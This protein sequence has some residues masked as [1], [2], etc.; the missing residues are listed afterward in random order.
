M[1]QISRIYRTI[2]QSKPFP[3]ENELFRVWS[4]EVH[5]RDAINFSQVNQSKSDNLISLKPELSK[6]SL[7][8][9]DLVSSSWCVC[10]DV[11]QKYPLR[12][13]PSA[14]ISVPVM[15]CSV[16]NHC[17]VGHSRVFV[18][19]NSI[20]KSDPHKNGLFSPSKFVRFCHNSAKLGLIGLGFIK[21]VGFLSL[22]VF[23]LW[24]AR[25]H[26]HEPGPTV[27]TGR[28]RQHPSLAQSTTTNGTVFRSLGLGIVHDCVSSLEGRC[29]EH[30]W[31]PSVSVI[32][33][34]R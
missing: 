17:M 4:V 22:S 3:L 8:A 23:M 25:D 2:R 30:M 20:C 21:R 19:K 14:E 6:T 13:Q 32:F 34:L 5:F 31:H 26:F 7:V 29:F 28:P 18:M 15:S 9:D 33:F 27:R 12:L 1:Y 16:L 10:W 24:E 11:I